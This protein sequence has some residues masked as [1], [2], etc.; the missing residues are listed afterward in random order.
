MSCVGCIDGY[1]GC[2]C[3]FCSSL[4][5]PCPALPC[6][7][8]PCCAIHCSTLL[9]PTEPFPVLPYPALF[10][11][12]LPCS[13]LPCHFLPCPAMHSSALP[14]CPMKRQTELRLPTRYNHTCALCTP[15]VKHLNINAQMNSYTHTRTLSLFHTHTYIHTY[16]YTLINTHTGIKSTIAENGQEAVDVVMEMGHQFDIIFMDHTM[17]VMVR[18]YFHY[19]FLTVICTVLLFSIGTVNFKPYLLN[20]N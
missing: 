10:C 16:T 4:I 18:T 13:A 11:S 9:C 6:T 1:P 8:L 12:A 19:H 15:T 2:C 7:D 3:C 14:C 17:P 5:W 20:F